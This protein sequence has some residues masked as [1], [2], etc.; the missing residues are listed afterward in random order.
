MSGG[1]TGRRKR[2]VLGI[3]L[4]KRGRGGRSRTKSSR[5]KKRK[6]TASKKAKSR[7]HKRALRLIK[8]RTFIERINFT[9]QDI[10]W[11]HTTIKSADV[12]LALAATKTVAA[13]TYITRSLFASASY[14]T[15]GVPMAYGDSLLPYVMA[16]NNTFARSTNY[17]FT[18]AAAQIVEGAQSA[19]IQNLAA[20]TDVE[21]SLQGPVGGFL[22]FASNLQGSSRTTTAADQGRGL[23][24]QIKKYTDH[25]TVTNA[26]NNACRVRVWAIR[27][28]EMFPI[29]GTYDSATIA[30]A[31]GNTNTYIQG[32]GDF[33]DQLEAAAIMEEY[34]DQ[35]IYYD[36]QAV[37]LTYV[38]YTIGGVS[39]GAASGCVN[40]H[41]SAIWDQ[42]MTKWR[43][44]KNINKIKKY[45]EF[46]LPIGGSKTFSLSYK[47]KAI[48][49]ST[50]AKQVVQSLVNSSNDRGE[51]RN[52]IKLMFQCVGDN[53]I[54]NDT[55][56][57][58]DKSGACIAIKNVRDIIHRTVGDHQPPMKFVDN[59]I[60]STSAD[61]FSRKWQLGDPQ[62]TY[63][64]P[65]AAGPVLASGPGHIKT[66]AHMYDAST[67][68]WIPQIR[69]PTA[70]TSLYVTQV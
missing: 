27:R 63:Q 39:M 19:A 62:V 57:Q 11:D 2:R 18:P 70:G 8:P 12:C 54:S 47:P 15:L 5:G 3:R 6:R 23:Y 49:L 7:L 36:H 68:T 41:Y 42:P 48:K 32:S 4:R 20:Y 61:G 33:E 65:M 40:S 50:L 45:K 43:A 64:V 60:W 59:A 10:P 67:S 55:D 13:N 14:N 69:A 30:G 35:S 37:P 66:D 38:T 22:T 21:A 25:Y 1:G 9:N 58:V 34:T 51:A 44:L 46:S 28:K 24:L 26:A 17:D 56:Y 31:G 52:H 53:R 29:I 16:A